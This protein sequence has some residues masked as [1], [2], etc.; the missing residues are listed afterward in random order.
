MI[1]IDLL[2]E[3]LRSPA[4]GD[5]RGGPGRAGTRF[6]SRGTALVVAALTIPPG[7]AFLWWT[8][9]SEATALHVR[10]EAASADSARLA[11]LRA[12]SDSLAERFRQIRERVGL[13]EQ[14]DRDRFTWPR[15]LDEI[16]WALPGPA[17]LISL[18]QLAPPPDVMVELQ[19]VAASP[20]AITR[21]ARNLGTSEY[22]VDVQILG[23]Q[24]QAVP[25]EEW[26]ARH[27]FTLVLRFADAPGVRRAEPTIGSGGG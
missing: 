1:E 16:S 17:W 25:T 3:S 11:G 12:A 19:G 2:P 23:S 9:R 20:L 14:L 8:Q 21:F 27:A 7:A 4:A 15:I 22:V 26:A 18:R 5:R 24:Q 13:V 6:G 10:L